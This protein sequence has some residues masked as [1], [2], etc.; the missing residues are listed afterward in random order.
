MFQTNEKGSKTPNDRIRASARILA[1]TLFAF[2][3]ATLAISFPF[4]AAI[5]TYAG[6]GVQ[7]RDQEQPLD[8]SAAATLVNELKGTL[9]RFIDDKE[10]VS[11]IGDKWDA[12]DLSGKTRSQILSLLFEDVKSLVADNN[13][14]G[15]IWSDWQS[16]TP[17]PVAPKSTAATP[18]LTR[19][20]GGRNNTT[21]IMVSTTP[22]TDPP[23]PVTT[24]T[25]VPPVNPKSP[26]ERRADELIALNIQARGGY[27]KI[28]S[29]NTLRLTGQIAMGQ[30]MQIPATQ[31][32]ARP[33]K[34]RSELIIQGTTNV[35]AYD[36]NQGWKVMPMLG[37]PKSQAVTGSELEALQAKADFD[38][39][40][41]D[42]DAK[43]FRAEFVANVNLEGLPAYKLKFTSNKNV[44]TF[45]WID[46]EQNLVSQ[47]STTSNLNGQSVEVLTIFGDY[48]M[49]SGVLFA[50]SII[51]RLAANPGNG[52][53]FTVTL[54]EVNPAIDAARFQ[55]P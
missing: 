25:P 46:T 41:V 53:V 29:V 2:C 18:N 30:G 11:S 49:V 24:P 45:V 50:H 35:E 37:N 9:E 22:T 51:A 12:R 33:G 34:V 40:L 48:R 38:G 16:R 47:S 14:R 17:E 8:Q 3:F 44:I 1:F 39:M 43:G 21:P 27:Q 15:S 36:G 7:K 13:T 28:K 32:Y 20:P 23:T 19:V 4:G 52:Q 54:T 55:R 42:H 10:T 6:S 31:E 26:A 5:S